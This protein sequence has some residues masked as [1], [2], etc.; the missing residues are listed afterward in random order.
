MREIYESKY[1]TSEEDILSYFYDEGSKFFKCGQGYYDDFV[2]IDCKVGEGYYTVDIKAEIGSAKQD[3]GD[4]VYFVVGIGNV[5]YEKWSTDRVAK[6]LDIKELT[7][8]DKLLH[9][10]GGLYEYL[11]EGVH[12]ESEEA[13]VVYK[14][15]DDNIWVRP[16]SMF[17]SEVEV[18]GKLVPRF[19]TIK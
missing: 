16:K 1:L 2:S 19:E 17:F 5:S 14:D 4:R 13:V 15:K 6:E 7:Y 3:R 10:K 9:Y 11:Y 18:E 12:T 8:G